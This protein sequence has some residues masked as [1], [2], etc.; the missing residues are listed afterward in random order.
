MVT[1]FLAT[2]GVQKQ[3]KSL[4]NKSFFWYSEKVK[5]GTSLEI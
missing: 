3:F 1:R 5:A 2:V 4:D